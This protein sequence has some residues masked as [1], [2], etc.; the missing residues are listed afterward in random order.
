MKSILIAV[1][2]DL[3]HVCSRKHAADVFIS[4]ALINCA[5]LAFPTYIYLCYT[6]LL[7]NKAVEAMILASGAIIVIMVIS[8]FMENIRQGYLKQEKQMVQFL[9][10]KESIET[11]KSYINGEHTKKWID[12][13]EERWKSIELYF[14]ENGQLGKNARL[15][16]SS[17]ISEDNQT[18]I[19]NIC[20]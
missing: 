5:K 11:I 16:G 20:L 9:E 3:K 4:T 19:N 1:I 12:D 6:K 18:I 2:N 14:D 15:K 7:P 13:D 17:L 8:S 10:K